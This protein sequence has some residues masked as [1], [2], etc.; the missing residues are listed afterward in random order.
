MTK[1]TPNHIAII[2]DGNNR[3]AKANRLSTKD[4]HKK[5]AEVAKNIVRAA[6]EEGVKYLT[7]YAFSSEN[8]NRPKAE[9]SAIKLLLKYYLSDE[10]T[11]LLEKGVKLDFIGDVTAFGKDIE[12]RCIE[13]RDLSQDNDLIS[14]N[15]ALNYGSRQEIEN[16]FNLILA[17]GEK[18]TQEN[19]SKHLYSDFPDPDL[20][21]RTGGEQRISNFLLWQMAY[22]ELYF[23]NTLWPDFD[24]GNLD[25]AI[26]DFSS[27]ERRFG[28]R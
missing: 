23:T 28:G 25:S 19:I 18:V 7:L 4:G 10:A 16:A 1:P 6:A 11:K 15:I 13:L 5:G 24:E 22:T 14:V 26:E 17:S 9:I 12:K 3:W 21:I 27:R 20:L 8:W 2:M